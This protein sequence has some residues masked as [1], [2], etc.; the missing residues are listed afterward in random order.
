[1]V[2]GKLATGGAW[3]KLGITWKSHER[4]AHASIL[5]SA[6]PF[7]AEQRKHMQAWMDEIYG[8]F[9]GHVVAIRGDR[10]TKPI[11]ELAGGRVYTGRQALEL[12]L[13]DKIGTLDDAVK[14]AAVE[15]KLEKYELR[16]V[17]EPKNFLETLLEQATGET[18]DGQTVSLGAR[19]LVNRS[20]L[21]DAAMPYI[22]KLD[23][24]RLRAVMVALK[25]LETLDK[26][27]VVLMMPELLISH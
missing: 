3:Q 13:V 8:V 15:A 21:I 6:Q 4:G 9:K 2:G 20:S 19:S 10:L 11:D 14:F 22:E 23:P 24:Q 27:G 1:M 16:V 18:D 5:S 25:Q 12:G 7:T 17:P 26:E